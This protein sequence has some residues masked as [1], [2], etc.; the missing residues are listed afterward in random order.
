M[1][2]LTHT[3]R[4][5]QAINKSLSALGDVVAALASK[6]KSHVPFRNSKLTFLLQDSLCGQSKVGCGLTMVCLQM[7]LMSYVAWHGLS[8]QVLMFVNISPV[9]YNVSETM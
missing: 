4:P 8:V 5:Q 9:V 2:R 7:S 6:K 1:C 3:F